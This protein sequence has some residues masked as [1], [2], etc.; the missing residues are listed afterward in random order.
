MRAE[1]EDVLHQEHEPRR[2]GAPWA[3]R[4]VTLTG[5]DAGARNAKF[6]L[7]RACALAEKEE[8]EEEEEEEKGSEKVEAVGDLQVGLLTWN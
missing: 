3:L 6:D 4:R 1:I 7:V 8:E 2:R 5:D